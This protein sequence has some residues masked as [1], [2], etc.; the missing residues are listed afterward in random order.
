MK[1]PMVFASIYPEDT[2]SYTGD[3]KLGVRVG[4]CELFVS[5]LYNWQQYQVSLHL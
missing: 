3:I 5:V 2:H 4:L 1:W